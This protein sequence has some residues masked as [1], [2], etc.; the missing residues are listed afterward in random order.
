MLKLILDPKHLISTT[1]LHLKPKLIF[2][3]T[4]KGWSSTNTQIEKS[5]SQVL[6]QRSHFSLAQSQNAK[7]QI[8]MS[9]TQQ[10][11]AAL[12]MNYLSAGY[13]QSQTY[14]TIPSS[15]PIISDFTCIYSMHFFTSKTSQK[16]LVCSFPCIFSKDF[17]LIIE[18]PVLTGSPRTCTSPAVSITTQPSP[19]FLIF[20]GD[21][22]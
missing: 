20:S 17:G 11:P 7:H 3:I 22:R 15:S 12:N 10:R 16:M 9:N 6:K 5:H 18:G 19:C 13:A 4:H 14:K 8:R 1:S 21:A 2:M